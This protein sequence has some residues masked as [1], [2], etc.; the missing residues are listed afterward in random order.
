MIESLSLA[1]NDEA[2]EM[3]SQISEQLNKDEAKEKIWKK[4]LEQAKPALDFTL[5][6][7]EGNLVSLKDLR[8]KVVLVNFWFPA[9]GPCQMEF[10]HIQKIYDKYKDQGFAVLLIQIAQTQEEGKKFLDDHN[11]TMTALYSDG[12]WAEENY[13]VK[14]APTNIFIDGKG[15]VIFKSTGYSPGSEKEIESQIKELLEY[16]KK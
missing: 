6:D 14:V 12:K 3:L 7:L 13:D 11:Y 10:P 9:C 15:R 1:A 16:E 5:P 8:G 4:R 2:N